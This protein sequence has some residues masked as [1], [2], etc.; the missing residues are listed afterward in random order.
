MAKLGFSLVWLCLL[1]FGLFP[2]FKKN[3][4]KTPAGKN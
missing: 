3:A 1:W 4:G 2:C